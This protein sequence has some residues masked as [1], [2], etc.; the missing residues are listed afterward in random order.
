[1]VQKV[2]FHQNDPVLFRK[3]N[4]NTDDIKL[5]KKNQ[6]ITEFLIPKNLK[7]THLLLMSQTKIL[8]RDYIYN[9]KNLA[10]LDHVILYV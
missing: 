5:K 7:M 3:F 8:S 4:S 10:T 1:M 9:N 2:L 6:K